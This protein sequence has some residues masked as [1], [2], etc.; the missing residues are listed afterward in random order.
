M[1]NEQNSENPHNQQLN[2]AGVTTRF[3]FHSCKFLS[4]TEHEQN[5]LKTKEPH[6]CER[7]NKHIKHNGFHPSLP[8]LSECDY[9]NSELREKRF[10]TQTP[11]FL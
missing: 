4:I 7:Y 10:D 1:N 2:I 11:L 3:C 8:M 9:D 6:I 5:R